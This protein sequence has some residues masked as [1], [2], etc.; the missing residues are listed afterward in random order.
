MRSGRRGC[1]RARRVG[2]GPRQW[3][4]GQLDV[5]RFGVIEEGTHA[6]V[7]VRPF[8]VELRRSRLGVVSCSHCMCGHCS[9]HGFC[10]F[11]GLLSR[12]GSSSMMG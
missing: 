1:R 4:G 2:R 11:L 7:L 8:G 5:I 12:R 10:E 3:P 9:R 6:A